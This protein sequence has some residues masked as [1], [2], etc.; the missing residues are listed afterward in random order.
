MSVTYL[1]AKADPSLLDD[2]GPLYH[3]YRLFGVENQQIENFRVNQRCKESIILGY[4]LAAL[5]KARHRCD[6]APSFAELF[7]ADGY[8][9][10]CAAYFGANPAVGFDNNRDGWSPNGP[11]IARRLGLNNVSFQWG[12]VNELTGANMYD[13]VANIGG[14]YHVSDPVSVLRKSYDL[15]RRYLVVQTVVTMTN[16]DPNYFVQPAPGWQHGNR[17][18]AQSF[19]NM[20]VA[21]GYRIIDVTF[22]QLEG[23][24]RAEDRGSVYMLIE[25]Q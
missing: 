12:D 15:A 11:E 8:F 25:K 22:N 13:V 4:I 18:S 16:N 20:V 21:Q 2:L 24:E 10:M 17:Y 5:G 23:N 7:C 3:S 1:P 14:L 6:D 9:T 19:A